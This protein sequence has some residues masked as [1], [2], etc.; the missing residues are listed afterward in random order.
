M[1]MNVEIKKYDWLYII[2]AIVIIALLAQGD[3]KTAVE[4]IEKLISKK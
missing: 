2:V 4:I 1:K 3:I